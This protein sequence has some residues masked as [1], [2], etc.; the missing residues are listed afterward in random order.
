M[1][2]V[3]E[4]SRK[5]LFCLILLF[6]VTS[7]F[8]QTSDS[9]VVNRERIFTGKSLYGFMNGGSDLFF[10]YGFKELKALDV[11]YKGESYSI[12]IYK[13]ATPEDAYG[14]YSM[15]TYRCKSAD[16]IQLYDCLSRFQL[17]T[18]K[19]DEYISIVFGNETKKTTDGAIELMRHYSAK[20]NV[21]N[22]TIP[23]QFV[24]DTPLSGRLKYMRGELAISN[25][26]PE[27][28][29]I[30]QNIANYR[31][32]YMK[33]KNIGESR[34]LILLADVADKE[35]VM[36]RVPIDKVLSEGESFVFLCF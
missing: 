36:S 34:V 13:M 20:G 22:V 14:I 24:K 16:S 15:H 21:E 7:I 10:E 33:S 18:A 4:M 28:I 17:Q 3:D 35:V 9:I 2:I 12:E 32:W 6:N 31:V 25:I 5:L 23:S 8:P 1:L 29:K 30:I 19:G 26:F 27:F 11:T